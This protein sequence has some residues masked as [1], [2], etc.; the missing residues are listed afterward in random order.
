MGQPGEVLLRLHHLAA[1]GAALAFRQSQLRAG[2][3]TAGDSLTGVSQG[4]HRL[5]QLQNLT[6]D[7][8]AAALRQAGFL[9]GCGHR[10]KCLRRMAVGG[11]HGT[12]LDHFP[13]D[14]TM[15]FA[16]GTVSGAGRSRIRHLFNLMTQGRD[17]LLLL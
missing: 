13:A 9:T 2:R 12:G 6:A 17:I 10:R 14:D 4:R 8:A 7:S 1:Y 5:L 15:R 11:H 16:N 3:C